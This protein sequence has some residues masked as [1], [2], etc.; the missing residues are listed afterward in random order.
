MLEMRPTCEC[1][2]RRLAADS[3]EAVICSLECTFCMKCA[4]EKLNSVC[5]NCG[6]AL[7]PRPTRRGAMLKK[8]P[9]S[10]KR[11]HRA[12]GCVKAARRLPALAA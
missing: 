12:A 2:G 3:D 8:Y 6:G 7:R 10:T 1:C 4:V 11:R 5:P 9:S